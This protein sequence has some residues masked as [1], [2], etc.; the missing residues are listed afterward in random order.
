[1][2]H[3][4]P[5]A[6]AGAPARSS[7]DNRSQLPMGPLRRWLIVLML[8]VGG[9]YF[10]WRLDTFN[11]DHLVY[12]ALF[13]VAELYGFVISLLMIYTCWRPALRTPPPPGA[14]SVAVFVTVYNEPLRT[15]RRTIAAAVRMD[16]PHE[17]FL[18]DDGNRPEMAALA[19]EFGCRYLARTE[20]TDA[21]AGNMNNG[22]AHC[23]ADLVAIFDADHVG[24]RHFLTRLL[25]YFRD[26]DVAMVQSPQDYYNTD[27]FQ[28]GRSRRQRFIWHDQSVFHYLGQTGR[29]SRNATAFCGCSAILRKSALDEIGGIATG[30]VTEDMHTAVRLQKAG[31]ATIYH[32]EPLA[33]GVAPTDYAGY[34]RQRLR[35][36]EGN[37]Q[38]CREEGLP[39]TRKLTLQQRICHF[40]LTAP[41][42]EGWHKLAL[43]LAPILVFFTGIAPIQT[44]PVLFM[45]LFVPYYFLSLAYYKIVAGRFGHVFGTEQYN[46]ARFAVGMRATFGLFRK[47]VRFRVTSKALTGRLYAIGLL[48]HLLVALLGA[49]ALAY[50]GWAYFFG[51]FL[52]LPLWLAAFVGL[53]TALNIYNAGW[54]IA[55][56][57]RCSRLNEVDYA[58]PLNLPVRLSLPGGATAFTV[59]ESISGER[60]VLRGRP[61]IDLPPDGAVTG[62]VY[63]PGRSVRFGP[64]ALSADGDR[65][66]VTPVWPDAPARDALELSL[67]DCGWYRRWTGQHEFARSTWLPGS[68]YRTGGWRRSLRGERRAILVPAGGQKRAPGVPRG[69]AGGTPGTLERYTFAILETRGKRPPV[70]WQYGERAIADTLPQPAEIDGCIMP[71]T[72]ESFAL[73]AG[74]PVLIDSPPAFSPEEFREVRRECEIAPAQSNRP[75]ES[76]AFECAS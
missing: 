39:F 69:T 52:Y 7:M 64:A 63:L 26:P 54:V 35:W 75:Y 41:F 20:N 17:T 6:D 30:T 44:D 12:S 22:L 31:Y 29:D 13:Y 50:A 59:T 56:A 48:P 2:N 72:G 74:R 55:N 28:Y 5:M 45:A 21:K 10:V 32:A 58:F 67:M 37:L 53:W 14:H 9:T 34:C 46:M 8:G 18:L 43:Y 71:E 27:A 16:Y 24:S 11:E 73:S 25:G 1:M 51:G 47:N 70:V 66:Q 61:D 65:V 3:V 33:Y 38:V 40:T 23:D 36:G 42:L 57:V 60:I 68:G 76:E 4:L 19:E 62:E 15:V 49:G